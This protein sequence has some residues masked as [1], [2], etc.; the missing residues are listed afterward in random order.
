[1]QKLFYLLC[2]TVCP[3]LC[4]ENVLSPLSHNLSRIICRQYFISHVPQFVWDYM[5]KLFY[6]LCPTVCPWLC[7]EN[8]LSPLSHNLSR[9]ICRQYFIF[10]VPQF[11]LDYVQQICYL[12]CPTALMNVPIFTVYRANSNM[13]VGREGIPNI[14][15]TQTF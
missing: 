13:S 14:S 12:L 1:M 11:V 6:L 8:V 9:I 2:T 5:Q 15:Y 3:W 4:A 7:A 10:H